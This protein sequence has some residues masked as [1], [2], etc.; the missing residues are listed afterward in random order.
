MHIVLSFL[1]IN[2]KSKTSSRDDCTLVKA[3]SK[4]ISNVV[5]SQQAQSVEKL[6]LANQAQFE[7]KQKL[8]E[9]E[10][11]EERKHDCNH[12]IHMCDLVTKSIAGFASVFL[13]HGYGPTPNDPKVRTPSMHTSNG[14][15]TQRSNDLARL[16]SNR[17]YISYATDGSSQHYR[18]IGGSADD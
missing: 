16:F 14:I 1:S 3:A 13:G 18:K 8:K 6:I 9:A 7:L 15:Y 4:T 5:A 11:R 2:K 12:Q 10:K 17:L